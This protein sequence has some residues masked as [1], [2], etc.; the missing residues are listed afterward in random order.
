MSA[1]TPNPSPRDDREAG[2]TLLEVLVALAVLGMSLFILL[3]AHYATLRLFDEAQEASAVRILLEKAI[4]DAEI[5]VL[6]G[7]VTGKGDFGLRYEEYSYSY[8]AVQVSQEN[9]PGLFEITV[10]LMGPFETR[11]MMFSIYDGNQEDVDS[12]T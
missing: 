1:R 6:A 7:N 11:T 8:T 4:G 9:M 5:Q 10:E 2:F 3:D 12:T